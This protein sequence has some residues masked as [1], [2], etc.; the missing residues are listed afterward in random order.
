MSIEKKTRQTIHNTTKDIVKE[1]SVANETEFDKD[2]IELIGELVYKKLLLYGSDL[3]AF[4]KHAKRST[5]TTDDVKL[6]VR[7][8]QSL[9]ELIDTK[10]Q[11]LNSLKTVDLSAG[12]GN[13]R[14]RKITK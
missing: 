14:K 3:D 6:L 13:K 5:I 7:N 9:V 11:L 2:S 12:T 1:I 10:I 8:N 4:Q